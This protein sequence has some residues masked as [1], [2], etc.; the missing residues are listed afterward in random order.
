MQPKK[1]SHCR[2]ES[3]RVYFGNNTAHRKNNPVKYFFK[4]EPAGVHGCLRC[5]DIWRPYPRCETSLPPLP[6]KYRAAS[7]NTPVFFKSEIR[8]S[9]PDCLQAQNQDKTQ[10]SSLRQT[11]DVSLPKKHAA[12][13]GFGKGG[14]FY[15]PTA[16]AFGKPQT[17][18]PFLC[19]FFKQNFPS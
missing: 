5:K 11:R 16:Q 14:S 18:N 17:K 19:L 10:S 1:L 4:F 6:R 12:V 7:V 3:K 2:K 13:D 15:T 9:L 8:F